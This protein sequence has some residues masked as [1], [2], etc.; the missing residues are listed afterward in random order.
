MV[1]PLDKFMID[2]LYQ[3]R[4]KVRQHVSVASFRTRR[5]LDDVSVRLLRSRVELLRKINKPLEDLLPRLNKT[6]IRLSRQFG[7]ARR[8]LNG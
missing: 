6:N 3:A 8:R 7:K 5:T 2:S 4:E 1:D